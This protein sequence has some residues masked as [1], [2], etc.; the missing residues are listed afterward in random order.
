[1]YVIPLNVRNHT[2]GEKKRRIAI[3]ILGN[4]VT[5]AKRQAGPP[6]GTRRFHRIGIVVYLCPVRE[7]SE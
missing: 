1:M 3:A 5:F 2:C 6:D 7:L 4:P